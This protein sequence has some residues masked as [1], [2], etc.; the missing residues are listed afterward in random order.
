MTV[1]PLPR[2][3]CC[4]FGPLNS[5]LLH[6]A[7]PSAS[8]HRRYVDVGNLWL[9]R[10]LAGPNRSVFYIANTCSCPFLCGKYGATFCVAAPHLGPESWSIAHLTRPNPLCQVRRLVSPESQATEEDLRVRG[11]PVN[12]KCWSQEVHRTSSQAFY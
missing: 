7:E 5:S 10:Q 1:S 6:T 12:F 11:T 2:L 3:S 4:F 9:R 8:C